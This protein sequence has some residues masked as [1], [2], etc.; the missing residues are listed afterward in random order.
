MSEGSELAV[1]ISVRS[2]KLVYLTPVSIPK[3]VPIP[4]RVSSQLGPDE[5]DHSP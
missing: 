5:I 2:R 4:P 1:F 3:A